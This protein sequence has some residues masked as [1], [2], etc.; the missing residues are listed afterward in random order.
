V[1]EISRHGVTMVG[2]SAITFRS[3]RSVKAEGGASKI[4]YSRQLNMGFAVWGNA[5][6]CGKQI[7]TWLGHYLDS[8]SGN[9]ID[10][11]TVAENLAADLGAE[12]AKES[13]PWDQLY[14]GIHV[15]GYKS[16]LP[17][18]WH[19][20]CGHPHEVPHEPRL[21]RDY[22]ERHNAWFFPIHSAGTSR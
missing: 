5:T 20:H 22:P 17:R 18:L 12:L 9:S 13:R 7:D 21:Y 6:V 4:H 14:C 19:I 15:T 1:S 16:A 8:V 3:D 2:D 11:T 10:M